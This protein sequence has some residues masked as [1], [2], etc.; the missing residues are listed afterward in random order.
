MINIPH[1]D[2]KNKIVKNP[3]LYIDNGHRLQITINYWTRIA[4]I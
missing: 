2:S 1:I 4:I 3:P